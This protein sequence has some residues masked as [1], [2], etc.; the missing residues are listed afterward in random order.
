MPRQSDYTEQLADEICEEIAFTEKGLE[1]LCDEF[2]H[3]PSAR[4]IH[5]WIESNEA[6]RQKY[7]R[8]RERQADYLAQQI[9]EIADD[10][11]RDYTVDEDGH[12]AVDHDH[13]ARARLRVDA[14]KW[15][16]SKLA[17]KK[18]GDKLTNEHTGPD[19]GPV[20]VQTIERAIV[21]SPQPKGAFVS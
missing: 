11:R 5:R 12:E 13:I 10:G 9:I 20:Q 3:W 17:P 1:K 18:Y 6:F 14:R 16:A 4:T 15:A 7:A 21:L 2:E 19:G 8:A